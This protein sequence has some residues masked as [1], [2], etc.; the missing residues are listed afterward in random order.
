MKK[1]W[2]QRSLVLAASLLALGLSAATAD[3]YQKKPFVKPVNE[4]PAAGTVADFVAQKLTYDPKTQEAV[5]TGNVIITYG[6][7]TLNATKVSF[8]QKTGAFKA[9]GSVELREPNGNVMQ[10]AT[11]ELRNKFRDGFARHLKLLLTN[12]VTITSRYATR[13]DGY[14][15]VF[16]DAHYTAC[17][18]CNTR[19][20]E[21]LWELVSDE[22]THDQ[23]THT[24]YHTNPRLKIGGVTVAG[25]PYLEHADPS[26]K[27]RTGWLVPD[28]N[29]GHAYG[30]GVVTPY[31]WAISPDKDLT[32][33]SMFTSKQ[34]P[35]ADV[36]YRQRLASGQFSVQGYGVYELSPGATKENKRLR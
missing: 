30:V 9:N 20:G 22:T 11:L 32:F 33:R 6:P 36:E 7:Y 24:L 14:L 15:T 4:K 8:N 18:D 26:V 31:F 35:V 16:E 23:K 13:T 21:P 1:P 3:A 10:A 34:G 2:L 29:T 28:I 19:N 12:D 27:R 25:L 17:K 5:A